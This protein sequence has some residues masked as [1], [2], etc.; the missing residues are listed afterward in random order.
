MPLPACI[1][2][3]FA[4]LD[5]FL[6]DLDLIIN[7]R[8]FCWLLTAHPSKKKR[9]HVFVSPK[10]IVRRCEQRDLQLEQKHRR[11]EASA[12]AEVGVLWCRELGC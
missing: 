3:Y 6:D 4:D 10:R 11:Q 7:P 2:L 9:R 8:Y 12:N 1:S 5:F